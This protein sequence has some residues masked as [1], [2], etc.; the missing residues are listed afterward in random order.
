MSLDLTNLTKLYDYPDPVS[1]I[2]FSNFIIG[3]LEK[4]NILPYGYI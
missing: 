3:I 2:K 4:L 1:F